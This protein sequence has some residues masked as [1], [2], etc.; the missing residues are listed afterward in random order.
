MIASRTGSARSVSIS[1]TQSGSTS[2]GYA[3]HFRVCRPT[4]SS[5]VRRSNGFSTL[6]SLRHWRTCLLT[7]VAV[8]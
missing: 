1:A 8:P 4:R 5:R 6:I 2:A 7:P 3:C